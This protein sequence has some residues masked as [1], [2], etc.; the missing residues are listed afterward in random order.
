MGPTRF[1]CTF[2]EKKSA[3]SIWHSGQPIILSLKKISDV[4]KYRMFETIFFAFS[5]IIFYTQLPLVFH[6]LRVSYFL[7]TIFLKFQN[8]LGPFYYIVIINVL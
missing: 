1:L 4:L 3:K 8:V 6:L 7:V 2:W 5:N